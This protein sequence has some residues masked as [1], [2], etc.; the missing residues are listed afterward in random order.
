MI[1]SLDVATKCGWAL[2]D[3]TTIEASGVWDFNIKR[4]ESS[5]MRLGGSLGRGCRGWCWCHRL[6]CGCLAAR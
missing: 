4:D 1:L 2:G 3:L 5:G 6:W